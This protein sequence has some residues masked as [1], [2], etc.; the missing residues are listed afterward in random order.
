MDAVLAQAGKRIRIIREKRGYSRE[1][2]AELIGV[3]V[4]HLYELENGKKGFSAKVL[5]N[6][7]ESLQV[8]TD[9]ILKGTKKNNQENLE[10]L[11]KMM[12]LLE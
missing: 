11:V 5:Y 6:I 10:M 12:G 1:C 2:L 8:S 7:S 4:K 9:Y 3:S